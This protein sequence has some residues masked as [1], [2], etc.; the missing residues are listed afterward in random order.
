MS[1]QT[2]VFDSRMPVGE[3]VSEDDPNHPKNVARSQKMLENQS[4]AD[5]R[6]DISPPPRMREGFAMRPDE[7]RALHVQLASSILVTLLSIYFLLRTQGTFLR[8]LLIVATVLSIHYSVQ[9]LEKR[10][11]Y[12]LSS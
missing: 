2:F 1:T 4:N 12:N 10:T 5:T 6:Y 9:L 7:S 3:N 11:L 8:I